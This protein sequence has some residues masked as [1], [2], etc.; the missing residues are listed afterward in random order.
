[1]HVGQLWIELTAP[2]GSDFGEIQQLFSIVQK[3]Q[4]F[5]SAW[6]T[7]ASLPYRFDDDRH[8]KTDE[9]N[10]HYPMCRN[11]HAVYGPTN[12]P[13]RNQPSQKLTDQIASKN[14]ARIL[15]LGGQHLISVTLIR[16]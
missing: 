12:T 7:G 5:F 9:R 2:S 1:G 6:L 13:N 8:R 14:L 3:V 10:W 15:N 16:N 11:T 4:L